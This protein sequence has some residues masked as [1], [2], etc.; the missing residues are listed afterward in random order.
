MIKGVKGM[1][2]IQIELPDRLADALQQLV[3]NGSFQTEQE[4]VRFALVEFVRR[5]QAELTEQF[6]REDI[7]WAVSRVSSD[8]PQV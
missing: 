6:Q 7:N 2:S 1:A 8:R 4:I 3:R 5:H